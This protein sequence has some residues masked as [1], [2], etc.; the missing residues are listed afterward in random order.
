MKNRQI[1]RLRLEWTIALTLFFALCYGAFC[2]SA[3]QALADDVLRLR[4]VANSDSEIDQTVKLHV[5]DRVLALLRPLEQQADSRTQAQALVR[6][7]MQEIANA[8]QRE[9]Y[10]SG[11]RDTVTV[12]LAES[13]YPTRAYDTFSL[14][15]GRYQGLQ[16]Q[17]GA[18]EGQNWWC[19]VYPSLCLDAADGAEQLSEEERALIH[20]DGVA[21]E[22]RFRTAELLGSLRR[23]AEY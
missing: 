18:A 9:V 16:I 1:L 21:Y 20:Q 10:A 2:D 15:A 5:R 17:I 22:I 11:S 3:Q 4:V 13:W 23:M 8:A 14:P 7:H 12:C 6:A 19:V